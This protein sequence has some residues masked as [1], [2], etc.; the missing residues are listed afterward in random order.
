MPP[1]FVKV[2]RHSLTAEAAGLCITLWPSYRIPT[3]TL[4]LLL[5]ATFVA[6]WP[7]LCCQV[8]QLQLPRSASIQAGEQPHLDCQ[9]RYISLPV[10]PQALQEHVSVQPVPA[11]PSSPTAITSQF[12][13]IC[14]FSQLKSPLTP[15]DPKPQAPIPQYRNTQCPFGLHQRTHF[16]ARLGTA[17][18]ASRY[19][20]LKAELEPF[21]L[22]QI[23]RLKDRFCQCVDCRGLRRRCL[24]FSTG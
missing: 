2:T 12:I 13:A 9:P 11:V 7:L 3:F 5:V 21:Q 23:G 1:R 10:A 4:L 8:I 22:Q 17:Q 18:S 16:P 15:D 20:L 19:Q 14:R 24:G 6:K